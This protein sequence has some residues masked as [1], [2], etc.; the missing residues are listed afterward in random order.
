MKRNTESRYRIKIFQEWRLR[1]NAQKYVDGYV[2]LYKLTYKTFYKKYI[3]LGY[4]NFLALVE[5]QKCART[6]KLL[7]TTAAKA[8]AN[9]VNTYLMC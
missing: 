8:V 6:L 4:Q 3:R 7:S 5:I 1:K 9:I 2:R